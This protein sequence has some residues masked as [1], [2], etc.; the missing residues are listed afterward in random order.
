MQPAR[1]SVTQQ[2]S[3]HEVTSG[4]RVV[5][6][7]VC[8]RASRLLEKGTAATAAAGV[9]SE[10]PSAVGAARTALRRASFALLQCERDGARLGCA[11]QAQLRGRVAGPRG[12]AAVRD[13][14]DVLSRA[15]R[16]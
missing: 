1:T 5:V 15:A 10:G 2:R 14:S 12:T 11:A 9:D 6:M 4:T 7:S 8:A 3:S 13:R 16:Q